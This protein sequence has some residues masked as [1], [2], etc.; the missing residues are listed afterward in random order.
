[1]NK[2]ES[3]VFYINVILRIGCHYTNTLNLIVK[4]IFTIPFVLFTVAIYSACQPESAIRIPK[5]AEGYK[6]IY[7]DPA[8][9]SV[10]KY[11]SAKPV[12]NAG[13]IYYKSGYIFQVDEGT[14]I[15]ILDATNPAQT[16]RIGFI[17]IRG[18]QELAITGNYLFTNNL[19]DLITVDISDYTKPQVVKRV[20]NAFSLNNN[21][22]PPGRGYFEC[23]DSKKGV[24]IGWRKETL[25]F[26]K[27]S[28]F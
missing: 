23:P 24:I 3:S 18:C 27:C 21:E 17:S 2:V 15:H 12:V 9:A 22:L 13:K 4:R 10:V 28:N 7:A 14:G 19:T 20:A 16:S 6:P 1:M 26:P 5:E 25:Q 8:I 11:E